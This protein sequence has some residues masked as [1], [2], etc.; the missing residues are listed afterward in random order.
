MNLKRLRRMT[1]VLL[2]L[3]A[4]CTML[5]GLDA[6]TVT[7]K[8]PL[9]GFEWSEP[10]G[11]Y[12]EDPADGDTAIRYADPSKKSMSA[13][14]VTVEKNTDYVLSA[15]MKKE[16][17]EDLAEVSITGNH[18]LQTLTCQQTGEWG[19]YSQ[20]IHSG[21]NTQLAITLTGQGTVFFDAVRLSGL[22][23]EA[24][25]LI[26]NG[27]FEQGN[28]GWEDDSRVQSNITHNGS[29]GALKAASSTIDVQVEPDT[30]YLLSAYIFRTD[31]GSWVYVDMN[32]REGEIQL[33]ATG[34]DTLR[35]WEY[36]C[37]LWYSGNETETQIRIIKEDNWDNP[38]QSISG[39]S[40]FVDDVCMV[41]VDAG[42]ELIQ[43][44]DFSKQGW[45][46]SGA[47][48]FTEEIYY[49]D[50]PALTSGQL[51][52]NG[53]SAATANEG[54]YIE[55][56]PQTD[57]YL[58]GW[59]FRTGG[60][61][62]DAQG[63]KTVQGAL[64]V[65]DEQ[66]NVITSFT[67][68]RYNQK[69][70]IYSP[71]TT[72][73]NG[74]WEYVS[75]V[76]NSGD[77]QK[78]QIRLLTQAGQEPVKDRMYFD[79]I[80][81]R[82][83][84]R[85]SS[86]ET[87]L[88][89]NVNLFDETAESWIG[90][91]D[92]DLQFSAV[93]SFS[94]AVI[95]PENEMPTQIQYALYEWL[96]SYKR[97]LYNQP[98]EQNTVSVTADSG[99][100]RLPFIKTYQPG[101]YLLS[102][103]FDGQIIWYSSQQSAIY[104]NDISAENAVPR[105]Q[106]IFE[107]ESNCFWNTPQIRT[108]FEYVPQYN[109]ATEQEKDRA[110]A[111]YEGYLHDLST[112]PASMTI[113]GVSIRGFG[114]DLFTPISQQTVEQEDKHFLHTTTVL[115]YREF[116]DLI[117]TIESYYYPD[118][119]AF[120]WTIYYENTSSSENTPIIEDILAADMQMQG[121]KPYLLTNKGDAGRYAAE[122]FSLEGK[123]RIY[124]PTTGRSTQGAYPYYNLEYGDG[125][126]LIAIG[127]N[128]Q[129]E[130]VFDCRIDDTTHFTAGQQLF[131]AYLMPG[132]KMRTPLV[133]FVRYDGRDIDRATNLWRRW[134]IDCNLRKVTDD[135][136]EGAEK[137]L[138]E[139]Q[140]SGG[141][142][143]LY[144]EMT[145]ATD[146]NQI[147]A[148]QWY[149]ENDIDITFWWMDAGW[150]F[151]TSNEGENAGTGQ[152]LDD[153]GWGNTG[154]WQVD[155]N[156]FPSKMKAISDYGQTVGVHTLLWFEPERVGDLSCCLD[157]GTTIDKDWVLS[158]ALVDLGNPEAVDWIKN[159]ISQILGEG[160]IYMYREDFNI[161][162]LSYWRNADTSDRQGVTEN[163][164]I[165][166]HLEIWD[167]IL[168]QYPYVLID[169]CASGGNRN[170]LET[171]RRGVALHKTDL[172]YGNTTMQ[173]GIEYAYNQWHVYY[174]S[175]ANGDSDNGTYYAS[176]YALRSAISPWMVLGYSTHEGVPSPDGVGYVAADE[177]PLDTYIIQD[178]VELQQKTS[179]YIY[180]DY[181][182]LTPLDQTEENWIA[183]E[184][185]DEDLQ[186]GYAMAFRRSAGESQ[187]KLKLKGL[188]PQQ[189]YTVYFEDRD[190][191]ATYTGAELMYEGIVWT[192]PA[193]K[194][195]DLLWISAESNGVPQRDLTVTVTGPSVNEVTQNWT[196]GEVRAD[197]YE[198]ED[199][200]YQFALR[201][202]MALRD[203]VLENGQD[204][205]ESVDVSQYGNQIWVNGMRLSEIEAQ[206]P[207]TVRLIYDVDLLHLNVLINKD[208]AIGFSPDQ[209]NTVLIEPLTT[210]QQVSMTQ[211]VAFVYSAQQQAW[212]QSDTE[213][214]PATSLQ[215]TNQQT[216]IQIGQPVTLTA[217]VS[218]EYK[219][220]ALTWSI[221]S[222]DAQLNGDQLTAQSAGTVTVKATCAGLTDTITF[223]VVE[224]SE[225]PDSGQPQTPT[226]PSSPSDDPNTP[227]TSDNGWLP[228]WLATAAAA[229]TGLCIQTRR[230][231]RRLSHK[232]K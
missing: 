220:P 77:H 226:D 47:A 90:D 214:L 68:T 168:E 170:D 93:Q 66:E 142:S 231:Y 22:A 121:A 25:N 54:E 61:D 86:S 114:P 95:D 228:I 227:P 139:P 136:Q 104:V 105:I 128:G 37:G 56:E 133:A 12:D 216:Q 148:I 192:L 161:A 129:W 108:G 39:G 135:A 75:G 134:L 213:Q 24:E 112:F 30:W 223:T 52:E 171:Y 16:N 4:I 145:Q 229:I 184:Y 181:Y 55:V 48:A 208:N 59:F 205:Y 149:I 199:G 122:E 230:K 130:A 2:T 200:F 27:D 117:F 71:G 124:A 209:D 76:W 38:E 14:T 32:D 160:G 131:R 147:A 218:P 197:I 123:K 35:D 82:K 183:W 202:N 204:R 7:A 92:F 182:G 57:Y 153:W 164:Y 87:L 177:V 152:S 110:R 189:T 158:D 100:I 157:D 173:Q 195:S 212:Q 50:A 70:W 85:G 224:E 217:Q 180:A 53:V 174:G 126:S 15:W 3:A 125:G 127:W 162:P 60:T 198:T 191:Y 146:A 210:Q 187:Q 141:T 215:I 101:E 169:S 203:T 156:R 1:A 118:Y 221:E 94:G 6:A 193:E 88:A 23:V 10:F 89:C 206:N 120:D 165:Q 102:V 150:Y 44:P 18:L 73:E 17:A 51:T 151:K 81:F 143:V 19:Y 49:Q 179:Q 109:T 119:A 188:N 96:G 222:G 98:A 167:Y 28:T 207:G 196:S 58:S 41:R 67:G 103:Q 137:H 63:G 163:L 154:V 140:V 36:V 159:R 74:H 97:T 144:H 225:N 79:K 8:D 185:F 91:G 201:M 40:A 21:E 138:F 106:L 64:Q 29:A 42:E 219:Q 46:L 232:T 34:T 62:S 9:N 84:A 45:K 116:E 175:K 83:A 111:E 78:V 166:G 194:T 186:S 11:V 33:R 80:S 190:H 43:D 107:D 155:T 172:D 5:P 65:V 115:S 211:S 31:N 99:P 132:E 178:A 69:N 72:A 26:P 20:Q 176:K 13:G 113:N